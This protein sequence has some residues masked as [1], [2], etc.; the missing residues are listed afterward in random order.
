MT[1][2]NAANPDEKRAAGKYIVTRFSKEEA[3][4]LLK[5]LGIIETKMKPTSYIGTTRAPRIKPKDSDLTPEQ[6]ERKKIQRA[7]YR[8]RQK[9]KKELDKL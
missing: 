2:P 6:R 7:E 1:T 5:M 4:E 9:R 8:L 3:T